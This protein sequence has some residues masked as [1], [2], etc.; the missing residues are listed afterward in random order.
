MPD[1]AAAWAGRC[2]DMTHMWLTDV[3]D[4]ALCDCAPEVPGGP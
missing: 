4:D 3:P 1:V 2:H